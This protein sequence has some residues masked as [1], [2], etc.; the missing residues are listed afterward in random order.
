MPLGFGGVGV[1]KQRAPVY[2]VFEESPG[3]RSDLVSTCSNSLGWRS[4]H[5]AIAVALADR[6]RMLAGCGW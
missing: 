5:S 4:V 3:R 1:A 2:W 6:S